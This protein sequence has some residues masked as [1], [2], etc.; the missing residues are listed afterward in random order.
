MRT[1]RLPPPEL[2]A[3]VPRNLRAVC[4]GKRHGFTTLRRL[5][6][7]ASL[8]SMAPPHSYRVL[9]IRILTSTLPPRGANVAKS[10]QFWP[11]LSHCTARCVAYRAYS[12]LLL[13]IVTADGLSILHQISSSSASS[14][15]HPFNQLT[16]FLSSHSLTLAFRYRVFCPLVW[17][18]CGVVHFLLPL[19]SRRLFLLPLRRSSLFAMII[20]LNHRAPSRILLLYLWGATPIP[21]FLTELSTTPRSYP[22]RT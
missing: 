13:Y 10:G 19:W 12:H 3:G 14:F 5:V 11:A 6:A 15:I 22:V 2:S 4:M 7:G 18:S 8:A 17:Q 21:R 16:V 20:R 9:L 1:L